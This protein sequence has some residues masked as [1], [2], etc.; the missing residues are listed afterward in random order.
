MSDAD[1]TPG[2]EPRGVAASSSCYAF[3]LSLWCKKPNYISFLEQVS[4]CSSLAT[5]EIKW[6]LQAKKVLE[7]CCVSGSY[8]TR[9]SLQKQSAHW[10][11]YGE[12][13]STWTEC[14]Q[15]QKVC[16]KQTWRY[17]YLM[18]F[19]FGA[20]SLL[21]GWREWHLAN[22]NLCQLS[23]KVLCWHKW[24]KKHKLTCSAG[25]RLLERR[26][27]CMYYCWSLLW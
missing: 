20:W 8:V 1:C 10:A 22:K 27:W 26:W 3:Q 23:P 16:R 21:L 9:I 12:N 18:M 2:R 4:N 25:K 24:M 14:T 15:V 19:S 13:I 7:H 11:Q 17:C 6:H 5:L